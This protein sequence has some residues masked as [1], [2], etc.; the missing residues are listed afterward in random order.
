MNIVIPMAGKG[1]RFAEAGYSDPKPFIK[2]DKLNTMIQLVIN[3]LNIAE[4]STYTFICL[5][6]LMEKYGDRFQDLLTSLSINNYRIIQISSVTEG[7]ACTVLMAQD[8]INNSEELIIANC[9]QVVLDPDFMNSSV[10]YYRYKKADGG[11]LSFLND[12]P[13]WSYC[14]ISGERVT[15]VVE[16]QVVSNIATVG[17]YYY[18]QGS[19]FVENAKRMIANQ[20]KIK[21]E[22]YTAPV[23]N[24]MLSSGAKVVPYMVN[25]MWGLGTP[26][27]L[28]LYKEY[29]KD[30]NMGN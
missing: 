5:S 19:M 16:K 30:Y 15:E 29:L 25:Q 18:R 9:D 3:N 27:D 23:Y 2:V 26:E 11:I 13:K 12:S 28:E 8:Q 1:R 21:G 6:D 7:S 10:K 14:R 24:Y 20:D 4:V 22:Y 17:I